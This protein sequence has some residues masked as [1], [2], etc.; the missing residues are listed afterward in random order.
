MT[1]HIS[2]ITIR[3]YIYSWMIVSM[4]ST[5]FD[6]VSHSSNRTTHPAFI[7]WPGNLLIHIY[8]YFH[9]FQLSSWRIFVIISCLSLIRMVP[10]ESLGPFDADFKW[11]AFSSGWHL[12]NLS[13]TF[14][15][16]Q[17][18]VSP[19]AAPFGSRIICFDLPLSGLF[20]TPESLGS[21]EPDLAFYP[22]GRL[23]S[24]PLWP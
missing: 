20:G 9:I 6:L 4:L 17:S 23:C 5:P 10:L 16:R 8:I 14:Y 12:V 19:I 1:Y 11:L 3:H 13:L 21:F 22:P 18:S 24:D 7:F 15:F 2:P